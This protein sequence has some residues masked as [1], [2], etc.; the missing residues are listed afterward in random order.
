MGFG[1][2]AVGFGFGFAAFSPFIEMVRPTRIS[3]CP[4]TLP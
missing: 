3:G 1:F 2:A 4:P